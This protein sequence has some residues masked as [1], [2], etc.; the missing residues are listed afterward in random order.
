LI[1]T[2]QSSL[3]TYRSNVTSPVRGSTSHSQAWNELANV[4]GAVGVYR[5]FSSSPI[6]MSG[7][8]PAGLR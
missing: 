2:P 3:T 8:S 4:N 1:I 6:P 7:G 5:A